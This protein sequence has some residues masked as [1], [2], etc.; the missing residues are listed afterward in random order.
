MKYGTLLFKSCFTVGFVLVS[1]T[2]YPATYN[3]PSSKS[4]DI[5]QNR[6]HKNQNK[7]FK[8]QN[9]NPFTL[10]IG[11]FSSSFDA[12]FLQQIR[13]NATN[14]TNGDSFNT[15][16]NFFANQAGMSFGLRLGFDYNI[17]NNL[18]AGVAIDAMINTDKARNAYM[19]NSSIV[20]YANSQLN[21]FRL[22]NTESFAIR[23]GTNVTNIF[24]AYAKIGATYSE[25]R[26]TFKG[27]ATSTINENT[28]ITNSGTI[29]FFGNQIKNLWGVNLGVG[30]SHDINDYLRS[31]VEYDYYNYGS[32]NLRA[33]QNPIHFSNWTS[34]YSANTRVSAN[35]FR[36]GLDVKFLGGKSINKMVTYS[37]NP[38]LFYLGMFIGPNSTLFRY[39][40]TYYS[41][42]TSGVLDL[43][44]DTYQNGINLGTQLGID[45]H[46]HSPY[47][48]GLTIANQFNTNNA[49][50]TN[51]IDN[52]VS[53]NDLLEFGFTW[54]FRL[55]SQFELAVRLLNDITPQTHLYSRFG[56]AVGRYSEQI[57]ASNFSGTD[58]TSP[59]FEN[60]QNKTILGYLTGVGLSNDINSTL[61]AF[62]EYEHTYYHRFNLNEL[63]N[64]TTATTPAKL[65]HNVDLTSNAVRMGLNIKFNNHY[66]APTITHLID[67]PWIA[68]AGIA[69]GYAGA[70][71]R[72]NGTYLTSRS[73]NMLL[74]SYAVNS[75]FSGGAQLG[76]Q[77]NFKQPYM[78][79]VE[80]AYMMNSN[81]A[82]LS[83]Y[84]DN[85]LSASTSS[86]IFN[87]S[88]NNY[89]DFSGSLKA[90][91]LVTPRFKIYAKLGPSYTK[92][93]EELQILPSNSPTHTYQT[94]LNK[95]Q[96][97]WLTGAGLGFDVLK[98]LTAFVEY[99]HYD[100]GNVNLPTLTNI[101]SVSNTNS[102]TFYQNVG[103]TTNTIRFG[104]NGRIG[105]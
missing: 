61:R 34:N 93:H 45:Y 7:I 62:V 104:I 103:L 52:S 81:N 8:P 95:Y 70:A 15:D 89:Y 97:G 98:N 59:V 40:A 1:T 4:V 21:T 17:T 29:P 68:Y 47:S 72:Y 69:G 88:F 20:Q 42:A 66:V 82:R 31:F 79:G 30:I 41:G 71:Y 25:L 102:D 27:Q 77:F 64:V 13:Y 87:L 2:A 86:R 63:S 35:T 78:L 14:L 38:F 90:G 96:W 105:L 75:A 51:T 80:L 23:L 24:K 92:I 60:Y 26:N 28:N 44:N 32:A 85:Q 22:S 101:D 84:V 54:K 53:T 67:S 36:A 50:S 3:A 74:N 94:T 16:E 6:I 99:D 19:L 83:A 5:N 65:A 11:A 48:I 57:L 76:I 73:S 33:W 91:V 10:Y 56:L 49:V 39:G 37:G 18:F 55:K 12:L 43:N 46:F 9:Y 58:S 100:Y